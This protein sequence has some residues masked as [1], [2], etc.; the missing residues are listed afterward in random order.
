MI[1]AMDIAARRDNDAS[2]DL[3]VE[4]GSRSRLLNDR[5]AIYLSTLSDLAE[6]LGGHLEVSFVFPDETVRMLPRD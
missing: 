5:D 6:E 4:N 2:L 3:I 1:D